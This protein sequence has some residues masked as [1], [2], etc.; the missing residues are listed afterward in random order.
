MRELNSKEMKLA[1]GG[2][3]L[4]AAFFTAVS[5]YGLGQEIGQAVNEYVNTRF[6]MSTGQAAYYTFNNK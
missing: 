4:A 6:S 5:S 3:P 1:S 2:N